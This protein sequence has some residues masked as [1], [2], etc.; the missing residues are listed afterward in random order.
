MSV[1]TYSDLQSAIASWLARDD[2]TV[3]QLGNIISM[4]EAVAN[5]RLRV[6]QMETTATLTTSSGADDLPADFLAWR[7]LTW[8]SDPASQ[9][10]YLHPT[11]LRGWYSSAEAGIPCY[12][13][14]EGSTL[15]TRP[16]G[17]DTNFT[18]RYW[19][20]IPALSTDEPTNWLL[21]A[22]PDAYLFGS[23][24]EANAFLMNAEAALLWAS[25]RDQVFEE[26][27]RLSEAGKGPST[28]RPMGPVV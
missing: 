23:L 1:S 24:V 13:T 10:Q 7:S 9:L 14:I 25:R 11:M 21:T 15:T 22:H 27:T 3:D 18:L 17:D 28:I 20:K 4:F 16:T 2:L 8:D 6:R 26:I 12:F 5:R 19:Q